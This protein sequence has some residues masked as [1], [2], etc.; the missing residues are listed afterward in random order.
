MRKA[1]LLSGGILP[2]VLAVVVDQVSKGYARNTLPGLPPFTAPGGVIRFDYVENSAGFLGFL[3]AVPE[4]LRGI[5]L[6]VG[7]G[8]LLLAFTVIVLRYQQRLSIA[9]ITVASLILAGGTSNLI[10]RLINNGGVIDFIA[11][12]LGPFS[13]GIFNLADIYILGGG[14][15]LGYSLARLLPP[16]HP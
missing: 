6:T 14:F 1:V 9:Q 8:L 5:V 13:T 12:T 10:D 7:V 11:I 4:P 2:F 16:A 15:Y 3:L